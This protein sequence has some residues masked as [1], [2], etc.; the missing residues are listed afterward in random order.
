MVLVRPHETLAS[1]TVRDLSNGGNAHATHHTHWHVTHNTDWHVND[2]RRSGLQG[3]IY[4][5]LMRPRDIKN[6][7]DAYQ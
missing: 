1:M 3:E 6:Y 4:N 2:N 7:V 5:F